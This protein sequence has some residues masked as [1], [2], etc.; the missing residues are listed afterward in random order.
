[1][2]SRIDIIYRV[3]AGIG[4]QVLGPGAVPVPLVA[5]LLQEPPYVGIIVPCPH[6]VQPATIAHAPAILDVVLHLAEAGAL[7]LLPKGIVLVPLRI[8]VPR[9]ALLSQ[10]DAPHAGLH[11]VMVEL[12]RALSWVLVDLLEPSLAGDDPPVRTQDVLAGHIVR[13]RS[14]GERQRSR[15]LFSIYYHTIKY[16]ERPCTTAQ[17]S[18][19][20]SSILG[21][22][23]GRVCTFST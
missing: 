11:V 20:Y 22:G 19:T 13:R 21:F 14:R 12:V 15:L 8:P 2:P 9:G 17:P 23:V 16:K 5:V 18:S 1:M 4:V 7:V 10:Y 3:V 6:V